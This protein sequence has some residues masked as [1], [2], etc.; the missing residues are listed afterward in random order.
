[1]AERVTLAHVARLAGV[2]QT[3]ASFVLSGRRAE[4]RISSE[5]EARVLRAVAETGYRPNVVSR[6]L[7]TGTTNTIG[8]ISDTVATTPFAG[9]LIWGAL[10]AAREHDHLLVIA[11]TEGDKELEREAIAMMHDR[12]VDGIILA[13]MSTRR[14]A[15]SSGLL[16]RPSVLL[17]AV[18]MRTG[19]LTSVVPDEVEAGRTAARALVEAGYR[20]GIYVVGAG[21]RRSETPRGA[22]AAAERLAGIKDV[23]GS[24]G[25][26]LA[27]G[28]VLTDW[29]PRDGYRATRS[30]LG[31]KPE[32]EALICFNDRLSVGAYHALEDAGRK[33]GEDVSVVSFDDD[34]VASW[35]R[36][37]LTSIALPHYELGKVAVEILLT[38]GGRERTGAQVHRL[39][40][41]LRQRDSVRKRIS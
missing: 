35:L 40:M 12:N 15:V 31:R 19:S 17:N 13:S 1:M 4:M 28:A 23:L 39:A 24:V 30:L 33:V 32:P 21:A 22:L 34:P 10:D 7:R 3:T 25:A 16:D 41:P 37:Q 26:Q 8:F 29:Q 9:H 36:P 18:P 27:G 6:S 11:E 5:V 20:D 2:S 38:G 14:V